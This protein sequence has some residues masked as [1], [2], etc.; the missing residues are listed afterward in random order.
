MFLSGWIVF[1]FLRMDT[2][3]ARWFAMAK[4]YSGT[5]TEELTE[6]AIRLGV[7]AVAVLGGLSTLA[8]VPRRRLWM[9]TYLGSGSLYI[10]LLHPFVL[11]EVQETDYLASVDSLPE[12]LLLMLGALVL[13][14]VLGSRPVRRALR[15]LVQPRYTWPFA[16]MGTT[17]TS[18]LRNITEETPELVVSPVASAATSATPSP[19]GSRAD[20]ARDQPSAR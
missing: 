19:A 11:R 10:Y 20:R 16:S 6:S 3:E 9:V 4:H 14:C 2:F 1:C 17:T 5:M 12:I 18:D 7:L 13:A 8:L 15:W